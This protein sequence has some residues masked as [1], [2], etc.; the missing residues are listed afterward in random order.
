[1][2]IYFSPVTRKQDAELGY[3]HSDTS[4][5]CKG[6]S[7]DSAKANVNLFHKTKNNNPLSIMSRKSIIKKNELN[8]A[9]CN[10]SCVSK[11]PP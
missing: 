1:M 5:Q 3:T 10:I 9:S 6:L 8:F 4:T 2:Q 7:V 11:V